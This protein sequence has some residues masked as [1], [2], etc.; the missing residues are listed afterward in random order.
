MKTLFILLTAI[1][2]VAVT[3]DV[4]SADNTVSSTV[5]TNSTPP[6]ANAPSVVVNNSNVC[7]T[8]VASAVQT[9]ILGIS[10]AV[11]IRDKNCEVVLLATKLWQF[12]MKIGAVTLL[13]SDPRVFDALWHSGTYA[14]VNI[15]GESKIGND[16]RDVWLDNVHLMPEGSLVKARLLQEQKQQT[17]TIRENNDDL[18]KFLFMAMA[19]YIGLPI[20]F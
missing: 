8:G 4:K 19:M 14:P 16:A 15:N 9:Q 5:V 10:N 7:K 6:T 18:E 2:F 12:Q 1:T 20:L 11:T 17:V 3:T 13:A